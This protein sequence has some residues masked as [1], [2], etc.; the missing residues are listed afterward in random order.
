MT[1]HGGAIPSCNLGDLSKDTN[2]SRA[3]GNTLALEGPEIIGGG[4]QEDWMGGWWQM[5]LF[6]PSWLCSSPSTTKGRFP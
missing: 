4:G 1:T 6:P 5:E 3:L 2:P